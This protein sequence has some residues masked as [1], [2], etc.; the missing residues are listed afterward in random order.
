MK[1]LAPIDWPWRLRDG[2]R[3]AADL[4]RH[5][6]VGSLERTVALSSFAEWTL[7]YGSLRDACSIAADLRRSLPA[8][9]LPR[10]S[11]LETLR[12][13]TAVLKVAIAVGP[14]RDDTTKVIDL[15][16]DHDGNGAGLPARLWYSAVQNLA[17]DAALVL[18]ARDRAQSL[19]E[20]AARTRRALVVAAPRDRTCARELINSLLRTYRYADAPTGLEMLRE[21]RTMLDQLLAASPLDRPNRAL[22]CSVIFAKAQVERDLGRAS[23]AELR[24]ALALAQT[25]AHL[26]PACGHNWQRLAIAHEWVAVI[27]RALSDDVYRDQLEAAAAAAML[28]LA[29]D[30]RGDW[31]HTLADIR[32]L[33]RTFA[34]GTAPQEAVRFARACAFAQSLA[35]AMTANLTWG[36]TAVTR[37]VTLG[38][39]EL[40][41]RNLGSAR[42]TY[43]SIPS[44]HTGRAE[45]DRAVARWGCAEADAVAND[46]ALSLDHHRAAHE[47]YATALGDPKVEWVDV[48]VAIDHA[49]KWIATERAHGEMA[50][51]EAAASWQIDVLCAQIAR[52]RDSEVLPR[53]FDATL[54]LADLRVAMRSPGDRTNGVE[55]LDRALGLVSR[56][57]PPPGA[58]SDPWSARLGRMTTLCLLAEAWD[59]L[60][61]L[62]ECSRLDDDPFD[63][64]RR[65]TGLRAVLTRVAGASWPRL[66]AELQGTLLDACIEVLDAGLIRSD[67]EGVALAALPPTRGRTAAAESTSDDVFEE[68]W[69]SQGGIDAREHALIGRLVSAEEENRRRTAPIATSLAWAERAVHLFGASPSDPRDALALGLALDRLASI[70]RENRSFSESREAEGRAIEVIR[71]VTATLRGRRGYRHCDLWLARLL[72]VA[73]GHESPTGGRRL[74]LG[75]ESLDAW[76]RI[77]G[78]TARR[79]L[80]DEFARALK[81]VALWRAAQDDVG[82]PVADA[83][84]LEG[85]RLSREA[86]ALWS[87]LLKQG[88]EERAGYFWSRAIAYLELARLANRAPVEAVRLELLEASLSDIRVAWKDRVHISG[89]L[90]DGATVL[91]ELAKDLSDSDPTRA[92]TLYR[93]AVWGSTSA[94]AFHLM[95]AFDE[96]TSGWAFRHCNTLYDAWRHALSATPEPSEAAGLLACLAH[97]IERVVAV[98]PRLAEARILKA[99][100]RPLPTIPPSTAVELALLGRKLGYVHA[101]PRVP[102]CVVPAFA[103]DLE[104]VPFGGILAEM[105]SARIENGCLAFEWRT[106]DF[107]CRIP[108]A[109]IVGVFDEAGDGFVW[110]LDPTV[111]A[112]RPAHSSSETPTVDLAEV[113]IDAAIAGRRG[114]ESPRNESGKHPIV[115]ALTAILGADGP[116]GAGFFVAPDLIC[117]CAHV[118]AA[119]LGRRDVPTAA[120][121]APVRLVLPFVAPDQVFEATVTHWVPIAEDSGGDLALLRPAHAAPAG[122]VPL[123]VMGTSPVHGEIVETCGFPRGYVGAWSMLAAARPQANGWIQLHADPT[124]G[125]KVESGFSGA[126][127]FSAETGTVLGMV[128][129]ADHGR[130]NINAAFAIGTTEMIAAGVPAAQERVRQP[131]RDLTDGLWK[132][133]LEQSRIVRML[134]VHLGR[135]SMPVA[136]GGRRAEADRLWSWLGDDAPPFA[137]VLGPA[138]IGKSSMLARWATAAASLGFADVAY[139]PISETF[140]TSDLE[141]V[142]RVAVHRLAHLSGQRLDEHA[143]VA[144]LHHELHRLL[145]APRR[146]AQ[147]PVLL[148]LDGADELTKGEIGRDL[149][150]PASVGAGVKI[151][152]GART[153]ADRG[154]SGWIDT[155]HWAPSDVLPLE[156]ASLSVDDVLEALG[157][158]DLGSLATRET[159]QTLHEVADGDPLVVQLYINDLLGAEPRSRA[160]RA[161]EMLAS[162]H[163]VTG[164]DRWF[165]RWLRTFD[166]QRKGAPATDVTSADVHRLLDFCA[167]AGGPL[168]IDAL[169]ALDETGRFGDGHLARS[170]ASAAANLL[171]GD[172][173]AHG[174]VLAHPRLNEHLVAR[175]PVAGRARIRARFVELCRAALRENAAAWARHEVSVAPTGLAYAVDR[176]LE[177]FSTIDDLALVATPAWVYASHA[178]GKRPSH[179]RG[180][181][182]SERAATRTGLR[183]LHAALGRIVST[184]GSEDSSASALATLIRASLLSTSALP[185]YDN[186]AEVGIVAAIAQGLSSHGACWWATWVPPR[187]VRARALGALALEPMIDE[188]PVV[189]ALFQLETPDELAIA[190]G[191]AA[192]RLG[193]D[194]VTRVGR[195]L[196][197]VVPASPDVIAGIQAVASRLAELGAVEA[198]REHALAIPGSR[199]RACALLRAAAAAGDRGAPALVEDATRCVEPSWSLAELAEHAI[200]LFTASPD[201]TQRDKRLDAAIM[202][203]RSTPTD[204]DQLLARLVVLVAAFDAERALVIAKDIRAPTVRHRAFCAVAGTRSDQ[205]ARDAVRFAEALEGTWSGGLLERARVTRARAHI[206]SGDLASA[207]TLFKSLR[208]PACFIPTALSFAAHDAHTPVVDYP[209]DFLFWYGAGN[210]DLRALSEVLARARLEVRAESPFP[211]VW[212]DLVECIERD[213]DRAAVLSA[214]RPLIPRS[215]ESRVQA[216]WDAVPAHEDSVITSAAEGSAERLTVHPSFDDVCRSLALLQYHATKAETFASLAASK[217][218]M[219]GGR[220]WKLPRLESDA[221][222]RVA[223]GENGDE[224][225]RTLAAL[226]WMVEDRVVRRGELIRIGLACFP[227][228][229]WLDRVQLSGRDIGVGTWSLADILAA[230]ATMDD[231]PNRGRAVRDLAV[232]LIEREAGERRA[233]LVGFF[234]APF[235]RRATI[236]A[237]LHAMQPLLAKEGV[238][239]AP[240][241]DW[242]FELMCLFP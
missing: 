83:D 168:D 139:V 36:S 26:D 84:V 105:R 213:D 49:T 124:R 132:Q 182:V 242:A 116:V 230:V 134:E 190:V 58:P 210:A 6:E 216:M 234:E 145:S 45:L 86:I 99:A 17:G 68:P 219:R 110:D 203:C 189:E 113:R 82:S 123:L 56:I 14:R 119:A 65:T 235:G 15:I 221:A 33:Q 164:L 192:P 223:A 54:T 177:H 5:T 191:I 231:W 52:G 175:M 193:L 146:P 24:S 21:C 125:F 202:A 80:R 104:I 32:D 201:S 224:V 207:E 214:L 137:L 165:D 48:G 170:A 166:R 59:A 18:G 183:S 71:G 100:T 127:L 217:R 151:L 174:Y 61:A 173:G 13:W 27:D 209:R 169:S 122:I 129:A 22:L 197:D 135:G 43:S 147:R 72:L 184:T 53:L 167:I 92:T 73:A 204:R 199:A 50:R 222:S 10:G 101:A 77:V 31:C 227:D 138:G 233:A 4:A 69:D 111:C 19:H 97:W 200:D 30:V 79:D 108:F 212:L 64:I 120:P 162:R 142:L 178:L 67:V 63:E 130:P 1:P 75:E 195:A 102:G 225:Y 29:L 179:G 194:A 126:P 215:L 115:R 198:A 28:A 42:D 172:G 46:F 144:Q 118:V 239:L 25:L 47:S 107:A 9:P 163:H 156:L 218:L 232:R 11:A 3:L 241:L 98:N 87:E 186:I 176:S 205:T 181:Q 95:G 35:A 106:L 157:S 226:V 93:E 185:G 51:A 155:F 153:G 180:E 44:V 96:E 89:F 237:D 12:G 23:T 62:L 60:T 150:L 74:Q 20:A 66:P 2:T 38:N 211:V 81:Q 188:A 55:Q 240:L 76:R 133:P 220:R 90:W 159:A 37:L 114:R 206:R 208:H 117:T 152:L 39:L 158:V 136:F 85:R 140:G 112:A 8:P 103:T 88:N 131:F 236:V 41:G 160:R 7:E 141:S 78:S 154:A 229:D 121:E 187:I 171:H 94:M 128:V 109:A 196:A 238:A 91:H 161:R 143:G 148:V 70:R 228:R 40:E 149:A 34:A 16:D 57:A